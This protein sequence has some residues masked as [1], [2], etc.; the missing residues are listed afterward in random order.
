MRRWARLTSPDV[1]GSVQMQQTYFSVH[2]SGNTGT[3]MTID[4]MIV[5][6]LMTDGAVLTYMNDAIDHPTKEV[7]FQ[8]GSFPVRNGYAPEWAVV[9]YSM[10]RISRDAFFTVRNEYMN[11]KVG[12]PTFAMLVSSDGI[13]IDSD[14]PASAHRAD[15]VR[16]SRSVVAA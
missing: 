16:L 11:D 1:G 6:G 8:S 15:G 2:G 5:N 7:P 3:S 10:F 14:R 13:S 12:S 9:N 4:G